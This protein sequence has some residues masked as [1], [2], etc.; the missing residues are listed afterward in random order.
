MAY[1]VI[2]VSTWQGDIDWKKVKEDGVK[3]AIIRYADGSYL[4]KYFDSNMK[5]AKAAGLHVGSYIFSRAKTAAQAREEARR[6]IKACKP[7]EPDLPIYIDLEWEEQ[8][9]VANTIAKAFISECEKQGVNGGIYANL[10]WF[11]NYV[12]PEKFAKYPLWIAQYNTKMTHKNPDLFGMWQY[13][14]KGKVDGIKGNVDMDR[15][16]IPYWNRAPEKKPKKETVKETTKKKVATTYTVKR[17]DTLSAIAKKYG[18]SVSAI[19]K[20][21]NIKN[22]NLIYVGQKLK[23]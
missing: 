4:D 7:Y 5:K 16:Y 17:G 15:L 13:S 14:S 23:L 12:S 6:I 20:K 1:K 19:A 18:T 10:H 2:D 3:G 9:K 11:N 22:V 8:A 21:N